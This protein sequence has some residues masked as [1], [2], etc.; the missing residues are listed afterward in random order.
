MNCVA[1][2]SNS[3]S[4][5]RPGVR[6]SDF[7]FPSDFGL[8]TSHFLTRSLLLAAGLATLSLLRPAPVNAA[9]ATP[10]SIVNSKHNLSV[11]GPGSVRAA[12]EGDIC[13]FCHTPHSK[14][15]QIP[16]WNHD[17]SKATYTPYTSSTLKAT[18]G[19]PTGT[20][21]LCLSCHD[22]TVAL[23]MVRSRPTQIQ[24]RSS[25]GTMP[26]G[27]SRIGTDL[28]GH[29]PI[30][31][32]YDNALVTA[33]GEL[34]DPITLQQQVRLDQLKQVQCTSC[35]DP[36]RDQYGKFLVKDNYASALCLDCHIPN[37]W[38]NSA[39]ATSRATWN[40]SGKNP[41][42]HT[43]G[44][45]VAASGCENCHTPHAAGTKPRLLNFAKIEDNCLVCHSGTVAAK[46]LAGEFNKASVHPVIATASLHDAAEGTLTAKSRHVSCMDCHN[47]HATTA[48]A[49][50]KTGLS[51]TLA[52]V[53]GVTSGG[54]PIAKASK[55]YELCFRC[56]GVSGSRS[57][58]KVTRQVAQSDVR[59]QFNPANASYHPVVSA[60]KSVPGRSLLSTWAV[61]GQMLCTDCHNND[62][63]PGAKGTG[64]KGPHGS[65]YAPL[66]ERQ[67]ALTDYQPEN[68]ASYALC[69]K[70]HSRDSILS[71]QSFR[72]INSLGQARGHRFH[73]VDQQ[74]ACSTCHD[75]HGVQTQSHL[76][77]FNTIYVT[78]SSKGRL[79]Y[80]STGSSSGR[81]SLTCHGKDHAAATYPVLSPS[82]GL[83]TSPAKSSDAASSSSVQSTSKAV[84]QLP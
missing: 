27:R 10:Y 1:R 57:S 43:T 41:W 15:D 11:S 42:P 32:T 52:Q 82:A 49:A 37:S 54:A 22:G 45:T 9:A 2:L 70:C 34:R 64:P 78:P 23:G 62:Q 71:D 44:T 21:K 19:Q 50:G 36:H 66:L 47:P 35:H 74:T 17:M 58:S 55:E 18:V 84:R 73:I 67:L 29:H 63:G 53:K 33:N 28:S 3:G 24:M 61:G 83:S 5:R 30:S 79:E 7:G 60:S 68:A 14:A 26:L 65:S 56:H 80:L 75:A 13:I 12:T 59:L 69:Y 6:I 51:G 31:F 4:H 8:Q 38:N 25:A 16:L 81:C 20:S 72:A 77:N 46:N 48:S 39:H 76:I 40:G